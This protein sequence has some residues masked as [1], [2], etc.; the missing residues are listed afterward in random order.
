MIMETVGKRQGLHFSATARTRVEI[1][2]TASESDANA[3]AFELY[4]RTASSFSHTN[5]SRPFWLVPVGGEIGRIMRLVF[6]PVIVSVQA[7]GHAKRL[8]N[9]PSPNRQSKNFKSHS[10]IRREPRVG[11]ERHELCH[12]G[13]K[14]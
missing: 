9:F 6:Q 13:S 2:E 11:S 4:Q 8:H 3:A 7:Y 1:E 5:C 10:Y 14:R 12:R